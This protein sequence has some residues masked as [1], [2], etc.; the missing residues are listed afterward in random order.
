MKKIV[1]LLVAV[2][3]MLYSLQG[4]SQSIADKDSSAV[5]KDN[6]TS[7]RDSLFAEALLLSY[8]EGIAGIRNDSVYFTDGSVLCYDDHQQRS[9]LT[10]LDECDIQDMGFWM[11]PD[12]VE[13]FNDAGRIR[14]EAF[15]K[16]MYGSSAAE[17]QKHVT[18]VRWCPKLV[19]ETVVFSELNGAAEALQKVS[20]E[21]DQH[22][23]FKPYLRNSG[24]M[25]WRVVAG[26]DRLSPHS[27]AIAI[28]IGVSYSNYWKWDN[29]N[30]TE[31]ATI[32]YRNRIPEQIVAVFEKYGFIWGGRWYHYD[33][34]HFEYRPEILTYKKLI[35]NSKKG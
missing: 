29:K 11:Y 9:S 15:F 7:L 21:L 2:A 31:E 3:G 35:S 20:D 16:K 32:T 27:W 18:T 33:T 4:V 25:A 1:V 34:M 12:S 26:T 24:T 8:P 17:V 13:A 23:E 19:G 10:M 5:V 6:G 28:D 30:A 14:D 22:P